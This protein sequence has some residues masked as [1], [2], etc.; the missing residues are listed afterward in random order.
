MQK[1]SDN[2]NATFDL[3]SQ[4]D[5]QLPPFPVEVNTMFLTG[6]GLDAPPEAA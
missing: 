6:A 2:V 3:L 1:F 4:L 5:A